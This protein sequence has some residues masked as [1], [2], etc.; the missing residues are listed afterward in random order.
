MLSMRHLPQRHPPRDSEDTRLPQDPTPE[1]IRRECRRIQAEW[2]ESARNRRMAIPIPPWSVPMVK[3][4]PIH[5][6]RQR[7]DS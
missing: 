7:T 2:S 3:E 6:R 5:E 1:E 4:S